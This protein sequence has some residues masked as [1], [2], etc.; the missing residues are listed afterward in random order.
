MV[1]GA[2][3]TD[4]TPYFIFALSLLVA[5]AAGYYGTRETDGTKVSDLAGRVKV[6]EETIPI[7]RE[8]RDREIRELTGRIERL[9]RRR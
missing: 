5:A 9:E 2:G 8:M 6:L 1:S 4:R 3:R 7:R